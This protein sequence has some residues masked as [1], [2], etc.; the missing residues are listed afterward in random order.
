VVT[1]PLQL[2]VTRQYHILAESYSR[3]AIFGT[4]DECIRQMEWAR[5]IGYKHAELA[6]DDAEYVLAINRPPL[7]LAPEDWKP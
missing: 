6:A 4:P 1:D 3:D 7:T 2:D 5:G